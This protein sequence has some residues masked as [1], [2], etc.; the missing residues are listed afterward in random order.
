MKAVT[1]RP[2]RIHYYEVDYQGKIL[3]TALINY[4]QD[5]A[6]VQSEQV[7]VG[8]NYLQKNKYAWLIYQWDIDLR[9]Y[10][11]FG[12]TV[13]VATQACGFNKFN[14]YRLF[15]V[16]DEE[17]NLLVKA[18]SRWVYFS[19]ANMKI[20]VIPS[21]M[22]QA[23]GITSSNSE[24]KILTKPEKLEKVDCRRDFLVRYSDIDTNKHVNNVKY[25]EW[26]L[27]TMPDDIIKSYMLKNIKTLYKEQGKYGNNI[28]VETELRTIEGK[29][30]VI[31]V[32]KVITNDERILCLLESLW[33]QKQ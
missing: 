1:E 32:H 31:G 26:S 23:Y 33:K 9:K 12:Q 24:L 7:G 14:A 21:V 16:K 8:N 18:Y 6:W 28:Q 19:I 20:A 17:G 11:R 13:R 27:E 30:S 25:V 4:F 2:Y 15:E 10:P 5:I 3:P 22:Y 29:N